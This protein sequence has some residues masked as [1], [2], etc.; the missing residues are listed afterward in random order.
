MTDSPSLDR[1]VVELLEQR[2][3]LLSK[4]RDVRHKRLSGLGRKMLG[5]D[6]FYDAA[7]GLLSDE[8]WPSAFRIT[9]EDKE[10]YGTH[11]AGVS[12]ILA[13]N[14]LAQDAGTHYIH[15]LPLRLGPSHPHLGSFQR[16]ESLHALRRVRS[17]VL[18]LARGSCQ[19][20][21]RRPIRR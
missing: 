12:S 11:Q 21:G 2:W 18:G 13:R 8:R 10:R 20:S 3:A 7:Y 14:V 5:Y 16:L 9:K 6:D 19:D 1:K 4:L 17:G 15:I